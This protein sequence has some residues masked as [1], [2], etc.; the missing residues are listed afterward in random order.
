MQTYTVINPTC[1]MLIK[2]HTGLSLIELLIGIIVGIIVMAG[3]IKTFTGS[4]KSGSDNIKIN[5]LNQD[6]RS[7]MDIMTSEIRRAGFVTSLP[8]PVPTFHLF[9]HLNNQFADINIKT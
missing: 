3:A 8:I 5:E 4:S 6:L 7:M 2:K 9:N 1:C